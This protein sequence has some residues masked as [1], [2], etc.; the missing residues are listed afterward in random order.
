M[1]MGFVFPEALFIL[2][3]LPLVP[4]FICRSHRRGRQ[5]IEAFRC[6]S[7]GRWH[8]IVRLALTLLLVASLALVAARPYVVSKKTGSFL[9]LLDVSRSMEARHTCAE[10]TFLDRAKKVMRQ[11]IAE[12]PEAE[13][14]IMAFD[15]LALPIT[16]LTYD[17][18]YL[19]D[20]MEHGIDVGLTYD[21]TSTNIDNAL[22]AVA[23]KKKRLPEFYSNVSYVILLSDGHSPKGDFQRSLRAP[24]S[25]LRATNTRLLGVGIGNSGLTPVPVERNGECLKDRYYQTRSGENV[26]VPLRD[27]ILTFIST[28][29]NGAYFGEAQTATLVTF[30]REN[31]LAEDRKGASARGKNMRK[32]IGQMFLALATAALSGLLL[33]KA[34]R[35][36]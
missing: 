5:V 1:N 29:T 27:D 20:V 13:F 14:G 25:D 23:E 11:V 28:G 8:T 12:V 15:R 21:A 22:A 7:I 6:D 19:L 36:S 18:N 17:H 30:L 31:G 2:L 3:G 24:L 10:P 16:Q 4:W 35:L 33:I 32:D 34:L 9:F 26:V